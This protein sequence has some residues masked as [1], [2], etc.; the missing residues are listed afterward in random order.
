M[1]GGIYIRGS[2]DLIA[3]HLSSPPT[4]SLFLL[5]LH[6]LYTAIYSYSKIT[7]HLFTPLERYISSYSRIVTNCTFMFNLAS[8]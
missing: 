8:L 3:A 1:G 2:A 7:I 4:Y 5:N 6:L